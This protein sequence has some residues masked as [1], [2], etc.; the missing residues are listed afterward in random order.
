MK[1][2]KT[3]TTCNREVSQDYV[4]FKCPDGAG[5]VIR[6]YTCRKN[7]RPYSCGKNEFIGP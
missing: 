1:N 7:A 5:K 3:C 4:E 2:V 6:C